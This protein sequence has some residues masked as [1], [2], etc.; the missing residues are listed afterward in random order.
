MYQFSRAIYRELK[1]HALSDPSGRARVERTLLT[2]CE[3]TLER[4]AKDR[5]YFARPAESLFAEVRGLFPPREQL[6]AFRIIDAR[7]G[8]ALE[9]LRAEAER[10]GD[11]ENLL[12]C[13]A[14]TRKGK[15]CRRV[16][17]ANSR[18]CPSHQ[19]AA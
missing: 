12:R 1:P 3:S 14:T 19:R 13:R 15:A 5:R 16:P 18:Y 11:G 8:D 9:Y 2:A 17:L 10:E 7:I 4:L 6:T